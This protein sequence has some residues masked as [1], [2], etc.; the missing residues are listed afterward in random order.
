MGALLSLVLLVIFIFKMCKLRGEVR[1]RYNIGG[2]ELNDFLTTCC[3]TVCCCC[4]LHECQMFYEVAEYEK[5]Q[6]D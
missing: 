2:S 4:S 3:C 1:K 5:M 6:L